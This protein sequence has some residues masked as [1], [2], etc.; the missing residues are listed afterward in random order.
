MSENKEEQAK[1]T[2]VRK[3]AYEKPELSSKGV[4]KPSVVMSGPST[5]VA[6]PP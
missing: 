3:K 5:T 4:V 2:L 1:T 6:P